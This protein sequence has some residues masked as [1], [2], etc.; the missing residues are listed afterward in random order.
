MNSTVTLQFSRPDPHAEGFMDRAIS[1]AICKE[2]RSEICHVDIEMPGGTLVGAHIRDG[3][4]ERP[5]D[6]ER[7]GLRIRVTIPVSLKQQDDLYRYAL[8]MVGTGYDALDIAGIALGDARLHA[9]GKMI[10]SGFGAVAVD[11]KAHIVRVAKD[12][13]QVSPEE[14]RLVVTAISGAM[15]TRIEG[16]AVAQGASA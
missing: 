8:S 4:Q 15:E 5:A 1:A 11:E 3:I 10:C 12:H 6:Y 13:W 14:L 2:T 9:E 16:D 7:W